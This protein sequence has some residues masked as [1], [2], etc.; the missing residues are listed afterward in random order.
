M[1]R[2][3]KR[4]PSEGPSG[5]NVNSH[6][7]K[8]ESPPKKKKTQTVPRRKQPVTGLIVKP[9]V[10]KPKPRHHKNKPNKKKNIAR[11]AL[12]E[13]LEVRKEEKTVS[14][15]Q[16]KSTETDLVKASECVDV[17][18]EEKSVKI[19]K[20]KRRKPKQKN[21][22]GP[23]SGVEKS[24]ENSFTGKKVLKSKKRKVMAEGTKSE[25]QGIVLPKDAGEI[26]SNW[27]Q[28]QT[29]STCLPSP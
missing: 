18:P 9:P 4:G 15:D 13:N 20:S 3:R 5:S 23:K 1:S 21:K 27:K 19:G 17:K 29:V 14:Q 28:F 25:S 8:S 10:T 7:P 2:K 22:K 12:K 24:D 11:R 26:S 16:T 6:Q